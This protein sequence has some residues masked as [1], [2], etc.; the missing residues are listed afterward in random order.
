MCLFY[1][2]RQICDELDEKRHVRWG[3]EK[4][5]PVDNEDLFYVNALTKEGFV[6]GGCQAIVLLVFAW[7]S[8]TS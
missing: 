7:Q 2:F 5:S 4:R 3:E 1:K 8:I 6:E